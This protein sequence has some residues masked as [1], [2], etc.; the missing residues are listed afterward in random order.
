MCTTYSSILHNT[1]RIHF[2][3]QAARKK[4]TEKTIRIE[5]IENRFSLS[6][7][8]SSSPVNRYYAG[9]C[10]ASVRSPLNL[11]H[12]PHIVDRRRESRQH[13]RRTTSRASIANH[14]V[15]RVFIYENILLLVLL[16]LPLLLLMMKKKKKNEQHTAHKT[17]GKK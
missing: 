16:S 1:I 8:A 4:D 5:R 12:R 17:T 10:W 9:C 14:T 11:W 7:S 6:W 2:E 15:L 13:S 3:C